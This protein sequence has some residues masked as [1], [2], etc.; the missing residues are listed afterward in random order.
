MD[1]Y[2][3]P[4]RCLCNKSLSYNITVTR[5]KEI[6]NAEPFLFQCIQKTNEQYGS[7][8]NVNK[9][10]ERIASQIITSFILINPGLLLYLFIALE[11][12]NVVCNVIT[13][14]ASK[15]NVDSK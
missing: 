4:F 5:A 1:E 11:V 6:Q 14:L 13:T 8:S 9:K 3:P 15:I 10:N 2:F 12:R 7:S